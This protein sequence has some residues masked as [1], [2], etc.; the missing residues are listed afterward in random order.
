MATLGTPYWRPRF[1]AMRSSAILLI[2]YVL[3]GFAM[4][5]FVA[6]S[7]SGPV[8]PG[9]GWM[10][11]TARDSCVSLRK[12]HAISDP[13]LQHRSVRVFETPDPA[14]ALSRLAALLR[15]G[16][17]VP[18]GTH[19]LPLEHAAEAHRLVERGGL[20][21]SVVLSPRLRG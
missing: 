10:S 21:E 4:V 18:R 1:R 17:L 20:R 7:V 9:P 8:S 5:S 16:V 13:R 11:Q 14:P 3:C 19:P 12:S 6:W 2:P 15:D